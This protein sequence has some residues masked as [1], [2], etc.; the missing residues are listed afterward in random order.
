M[1][2]IFLLL[3]FVLAGCETTPIVKEKWPSATPTLMKECAALKLLPEEIKLSELAKGITDN[4]A[5]YHE[6]AAKNSAW[7]EWYNEQKKIFDEA[8]K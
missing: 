4:Y 6:C 2:Y 1:R 3:L 8:H 5:L 7:I